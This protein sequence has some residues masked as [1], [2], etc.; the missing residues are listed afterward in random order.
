MQKHSCNEL[1]LFVIDAISDLKSLYMIVF[2]SNSFILS[3]RNSKIFE[4]LQ[5]IF[6]LKHECMLPSTEKLDK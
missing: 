2:C 1:E 5:Y 3:F 6:V 4:Q